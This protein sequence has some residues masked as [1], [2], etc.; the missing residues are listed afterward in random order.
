MSLS[1]IHY[2]S[3]DIDFVLPNSSLISEWIVDT[4]HSENFSLTSLSFIFC[5]DQYLLQINNDYLSHDYLTDII[6]FDNSD[7][8]NY[9]EGDIFISI[10][11]VLDNAK[12]YNVSFSTELHRVIIHGILHL[13]GYSDKLSNEIELM[14]QKENYYLSL[15]KI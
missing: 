6:T 8:S 14:R 10:D 4:I 5:S 15:L 3:E 7:I 12:F 13:L 11:R 1:L 9:L 2:F